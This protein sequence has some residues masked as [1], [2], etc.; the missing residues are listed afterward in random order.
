MNVYVA[1]T[2]AYTEK[3]CILS[4]INQLQLQHVEVHVLLFSQLIEIQ[5]PEVH[6]WAR[7]TTCLQI[8]SKYEIH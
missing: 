3:S 1:P 7:V 6:L 5:H 4:F 8:V 2:Y